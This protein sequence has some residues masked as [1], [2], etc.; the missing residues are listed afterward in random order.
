MPLHPRLK[1]GPASFLC[2]STRTA[3]AL[4]AW[5]TACAAWL[6]VL[7]AAPTLAQ[8]G[9]PPVPPVPPAPPAAAPATPVSPPA[10]TP[11]PAADAPPAAAPSAGD[12]GVHAPPPAAS[13]EARPRPKRDRDRER[14]D[15]RDGSAPSD[16][17]D[18]GPA[19]EGPDCRGGH[20]EDHGPFMPP[21]MLDDL[22]RAL[23][24]GGPARI[25]PHV[26]VQLRTAILTGAGNQAAGGDRAERPGFAVP[27]ARLGLAGELGRRV[28]FG[29]ETDLA[30]CD[31][32]GHCDPLNEAWLGFRAWRGSQLVLGSH[33]VPFARSAM[34]G[35]GNA[36]LAER[37]LASAAM[38]PFRQVG[39]SMTGRYEKFAGIQW[40]LGVFNGFSRDSTFHGGIRQNE[41]VH[42][43]RF[44][45]LAYVARISV[46]PMGE[47]GRGVA[48]LPGSDGPGRSPADRNGA[49][50]NG[51]D[52]NGGCGPDGCSPD[53]KGDCGGG[54]D[55]GKDHGADHGKDQDLEHSKDQDLEHS[56][57]HGQRHGD[58]GKRG[59]RVH[60]GGGALYDDGGST[61]SLSYSA[62]LHVKFRG[63]H[64]L[65]EAIMDQIDPLEQPT[66]GATL[67]E[68]VGRRSMVVEAGYARGRFQAAARVELIDPNVATEDRIDEMVVSGSLGYQIMRNRVRAVLQY[69]HRQERFGPAVDNDTLFA[70]FQL[71]L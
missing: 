37:S 16:M 34:L 12:E 49:D 29:I 3:A 26:L 58:S 67:P 38:A 70:Q 40:H 60:L 43:N 54:K 14:H 39:A 45:G 24:L 55:H 31:D 66:T 15:R 68:T 17:P 56:K 28:D 2:P 71:M 27:R 1:P 18:D 8:P 64:F 44:H 25:N 36:A 42:G 13:D 51:A 50:K 65:A 61:K 30:G 47:P 52:K 22:R 35:S 6:T 69:D 7:I 33:K 46:E 11:A 57:E 53:C 9:P 4:A 41:G 21:G 62:D 23:G 48:D 59:L 10:P 63:V 20:G 5:L 32:G 19:C